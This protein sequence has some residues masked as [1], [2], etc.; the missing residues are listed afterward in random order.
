MHELEILHAD[1]HLLAVRKPACVPTVGDDSGDDC[2]LEMARR[3]VQDTY[4]KPGKAY[5]GV[6]H[7]LDRPVSGV[8]LFARTS[9]A[10]SRLSEAFR[11]QSVRKT[12]LGIGHGRPQDESGVL[13][14]WLRKDRNNNRVHVQ[15]EETE[16]ARR[17]LTEW[18]LLET[19]QAA[20]DIQSLIEFHPKT[21]RS[22][23]LR[24]AAREL[25]CPLLG[26]LK[27][28]APNPLPDRSIGLHALKLDVTHPT[29]KERIQLHCPVPKTQ[30]WG[31]AE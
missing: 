18:R 17:A 26:D 23:Q 15:R 11:T 14:M 3:W 7:R 27:Y 4:N 30:W 6:V 8:V 12:Y 19:T 2:L 10:A 25:G 16:G 20:G 5:L 29:T 28:G 9:K 22:H 1:N 31:N 24:L 21:G 13:D